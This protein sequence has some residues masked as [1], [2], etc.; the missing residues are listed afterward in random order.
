MPIALESFDQQVA[1]DSTGDAAHY[2]LAG[3]VAVLQVRRESDSH[4]RCKSDPW[5][6]ECLDLAISR[7]R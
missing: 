1:T 6:R 7:I 3:I 2:V 5:L 4:A